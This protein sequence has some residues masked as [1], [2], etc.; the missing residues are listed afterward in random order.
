[1]TVQFDGSWSHLFDRKPMVI[2]V[3]Q[4]NV[5]SSRKKTGTIL[6]ASSYGNCLLDTGDAYWRFSTC[7]GNHKYC[8]LHLVAPDTA[9]FT[10]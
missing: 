10:A 6:L 3:L 9:K 5:T 4:H 2:N 7:S 1:M 8:S